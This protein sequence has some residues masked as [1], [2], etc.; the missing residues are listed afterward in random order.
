[1]NG[2]R[3]EEG[4]KSKRLRHRYCD[5]YFRALSLSLSLSLCLYRKMNGFDEKR[6]WWWRRCISAPLLHYCFLFLECVR[7]CVCS[8]ATLLYPVTPF[9]TATSFFTCLFGCR[10]AVAKEKDEVEKKRI[11]LFLFF[12]F[13]CTGIAECRISSSFSL[14]LYRCIYMY[15]CTCMR[16]C[17]SLSLCVCQCSAM[18]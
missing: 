1:M 10:W 16:I 4:S 18:L 6:W 14:S 15:I 3:E 2:Q 7:V 13:V 17:L 11:F 5:E 8:V 12:L 9:D